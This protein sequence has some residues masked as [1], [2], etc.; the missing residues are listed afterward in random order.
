MDTSNYDQKMAE[1]RAAASNGQ[2]TKEVVDKITRV[3]RPKGPDKVVFKRNVPA[4][5][6]AQL[7]AIIKGG[8]N[9]D[10]KPKEAYIIGE[11]GKESS[12]ELNEVKGQL[13]MVLE[14]NEKLS[15]E[16]E[17]LEEK[18]QKVARLT[19]NEKLALFIRKYDDLK[20]AYQALEFRTQG[21]D[22]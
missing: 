17:M 16:I 3:G 15:K 7:D 2:L 10:S 1:L 4:E 6:V 9:A 13:K 5:M 14:D 22:S 21:L 19:D 18:I 8:A 11:V 20:L 12:G